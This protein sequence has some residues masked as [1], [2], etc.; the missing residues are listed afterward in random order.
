MH[1]H[2]PFQINMCQKQNLSISADHR[3]TSGNMLQVTA[4]YWSNLDICHLFLQIK[5]LPIGDK[6]PRKDKKHSVFSWFV[7]SSCVTFRYLHL[8]L[9]LTQGFKWLRIM[10]EFLILSMVHTYKHIQNYG[11]CKIPSITLTTPIS[12]SFHCI[13]TTTDC[14]H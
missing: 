14:T 3:P 11:A 10:I 2:A 5:K 7:H 8:C 13:P 12:F 4:L 6:C 1:F 9:C